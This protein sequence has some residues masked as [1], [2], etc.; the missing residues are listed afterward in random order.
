MDK[1]LGLKGSSYLWFVLLVGL[2]A[3]IFDAIFHFFFSSPFETVPYFLAKFVVFSFGAL[4]FLLVVKKK[5]LVFW[6]VLL[7]G[8]V[9][10]SVWG[11]YYNVL[12]AIFNF[13]PFGIALKGLSVLGSHNLFVTGL[14]FGVVHT[15]AF[16]VGFYL[17]KEIMKG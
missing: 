13:N 4:V 5:A 15:F 16:V 14:F 11:L 1:S 10:A 3:I 2:F 12:P 9:V 7:G 8:V 6:K 17:S